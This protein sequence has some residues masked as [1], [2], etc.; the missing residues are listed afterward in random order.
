M[1]G[2]EAIAAPHGHRT[3]DEWV[4]GNLASLLGAIYFYA[5][6]A[7]SGGRALDA[8]EYKATRKEILDMLHRARNEATG[9]WMD[10]SGAWDGWARIAV[11]D[12]QGAIVLVSEKGWLA[13]DW[14]GD[15]AALAERERQAQDGDEEQTEPAHAAESIQIRRADTMFQ[16]RYDYMS[17]KKRE[18]YRV[19][20]QGIMARIEELSGGPADDAMEVDSRP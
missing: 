19:W 12:L 15:I 13:G 14:F 11:K 18:D 20:K 17:E 16:D 7:L 4:N 2:M 8:A 3:T 9:G 6:Q 1:A 5:A 10:E